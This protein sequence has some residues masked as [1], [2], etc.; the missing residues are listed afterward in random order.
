MSRHRMNVKSGLTLST[1]ETI[2]L[3]P[4][5]EKNYLQSDY[6]PTGLHY[7]VADSTLTQSWSWICSRGY[8]PAIPIALQIDTPFR[9]FFLTKRNKDQRRANRMTMIIIK[10]IVFAIELS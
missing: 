5:S 2:L 4:C 7:F 9:F 1:D 3:T 8:R 6:K 10:L